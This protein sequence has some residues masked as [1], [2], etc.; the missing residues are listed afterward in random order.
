MQ[1]ELFIPCFIDQVKPSIAF[2]MIKVLE[3]AG[4]HVLYNTEQT[5]CG[6]P[7]YSAG[8][9]ADAREVA[10]KFVQEFPLG[11][12]DKPFAKPV[13]KP[14]VSP[15][16][17]C[18]G[19][20]KN[21]YNSIFQNTSLHN[22][23]RKVQKNMFELSEFLVNQLQRSNLELYFPAKVTY[24]DSC[25]ALRE[26]RIK[27]APRVLLQQ[28]EGLQLIEMEDTETCCGFGG[29]FSFKFEPL[30][31]SMAQRKVD[32]A[33]ATGAEYIV[34]T[35]YSCLMHL[36]A[37]IQKNNLPIKVLHLAELLAKGIH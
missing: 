35:D 3:K 21:H 9:V 11:D 26:L 25:S 32:H 16:A 22:Q 20:V 1:V 7:A 8:Y 14:I 37:Y 29:T 27:D 10:E 28:V 5:C 19:M 34:S 18:V 33:L 12:P 13:E 24:H 17:S 23:C 4:C 6:Q 15:S 36:E 31:V 30:S 2:D